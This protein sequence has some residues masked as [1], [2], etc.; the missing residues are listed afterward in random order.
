MGRWLIR[1]QR[2]AEQCRKTYLSLKIKNG[3]LDTKEN[4]SSECELSDSHNKEVRCKKPIKQNKKP[5]Q[6]N[7]RAEQQS[8][9]LELLRKRFQLDMLVAPLAVHDN[10]SFLEE[11]EMRF[12]HKYRPIKKAALK[13]DTHLKQKNNKKKSTEKS[14]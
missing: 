10:H 12:G 11:V 3:S 1:G 14:L 9:S 6:K 5:P 13:T 8:F 7:E 2:D 4:K